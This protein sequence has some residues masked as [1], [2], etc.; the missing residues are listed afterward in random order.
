M[1][2]TPCTCTGMM[3][4][5]PACRCPTTGAARG[6]SVIP[7]A[8]SRNV[9]VYTYIGTLVRCN[10]ERPKEYNTHTQT[11]IHTG[12]LVRHVGIIIRSAPRG[13][14]ALE[15]LDAISITQRVHRVLAAGRAL[16]HARTHTHTHTH[17]HTTTQQDPYPLRGG[18]TIL[19]RYSMTQKLTSIVNYKKDG[20][21]K[22]VPA[23][24][25]KPA[26]GTRQVLD[27]DSQ[28][29]TQFAGNLPA[30]RLDM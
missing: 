6:C 5:A 1:F 2:C 15:L 27:I 28:P 24:G 26:T 23:S 21:I 20:L 3:R 8:Q 10:Q 19:I 7:T 18:S 11:H 29:L 12:A 4:A 13:F 16:M 9:W 14:V 17:S 30:K 25:T 22:Y